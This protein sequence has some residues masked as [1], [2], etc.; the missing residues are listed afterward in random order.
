MAKVQSKD[1]AHSIA[2]KKSISEAEAERYVESFFSLV[3]EG[4]VADRIVKVKGLGTF[5][6]V[7]VRERESVDVNT[8]ERVRIGGHSKMSFQPD[9]TLKELVNK[10]FSQFETV[11]LNEGVDEKELAAVDEEENVQD[12]IP[13]PAVPVSP[14]DEKA[15]ETAAEKE[16]QTV[17]EAGPSIEEG[18]DADADDSGKAVYSESSRIDTSMDY[19][20]DS[21]GEHI[22]VTADDTTGLDAPAQDAE[23]DNEEADFDNVSPEN[24]DEQGREQCN[25]VQTDNEPK[26]KNAIFKAVLL[27]GALLLCMLVMF[28]C[29]YY[30]GGKSHAEKNTLTKVELRKKIVSRR[31]MATADKPKSAASDTVKAD[32]AAKDTARVDKE[33]KQQEGKTDVNKGA[34]AC[35]KESKPALSNVERIVKTGAYVIVGTEKRITVKNGQTMKSIARQYLGEGMECYIQLYNGKLEVCEGETIN[36]PKVELKKKATN[37]KVS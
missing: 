4:L 14:L 31:R 3:N 16:T 12:E 34:E 11:V 36:I 20:E 26:K 8:G 13:A 22:V 10:P 29:G 35:E 5:K 30:F 15:E 9:A 19:D 18:N 24:G 6:L 1:I 32:K 25:D 7:D 28:F 27:S 17:D 37:K 21:F 23:T 2:K 33:A